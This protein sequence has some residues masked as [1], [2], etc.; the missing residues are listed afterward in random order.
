MLLQLVIGVLM[1]IFTAVES[2]QNDIIPGCEELS[3]KVLKR[4]IRRWCVFVHAI[5][6]SRVPVSLLTKH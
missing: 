5:V 1:D 3:V 6:H 4:L 2:S